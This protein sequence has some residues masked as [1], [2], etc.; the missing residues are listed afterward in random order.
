MP[1]TK[2][3]LNNSTIIA[4]IPA[5]ALAVADETSGITDLEGRGRKILMLIN[6]GTPAAGGLANI[7]VQ[8][9][10]MATMTDPVGDEVL[11]ATGIDATQTYLDLHATDGVGYPLSDFDLILTAGEIVTVTERVGDHCLI[12]RAQ[13]GTTATVHAGG[14]TAR[15]SVPTLHTFAE[16]D[17]AGLVE[18]D[19]A[20]NRRYVRVVAAITVEVFTLGVLGVV[21][22][23]REVPAG[24]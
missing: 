23:E 22:L 9:S 2:D 3:L 21:Y 4:F 19:L 18:A 12:R 5:E 17:A 8:E 7:I 24:I 15:L 11:D 14:A 16:I 13:R 20:P 10:N 1:T 6:A